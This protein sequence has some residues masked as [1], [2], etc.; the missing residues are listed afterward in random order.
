MMRLKRR[1]YLCTLHTTC[2][3]GIPHN[4]QCAANEEACENPQCTTAAPPFSV[5]SAWHEY[6]P[7]LGVIYALASLPARSSHVR[8]ARL[9]C[10]PANQAGSSGAAIANQPDE[11]RLIRSAARIARW[12]AGRAKS[13]FKRRFS[14]LPVGRL[15]LRPRFAQDWQS[16]TARIAPPRHELGVIQ[17]KLPN[18]AKSR[19]RSISAPNLALFPTIAKKADYRP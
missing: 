7:G 12:P 17:P 15:H 13:N 9:P 6:I 2:C 18:V 11:L 8:F 1:D 10:G 5:G 3:V 14:R 19:L 16:P 4:M